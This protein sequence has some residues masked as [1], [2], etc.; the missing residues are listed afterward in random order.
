MDAKQIIELL[1]GTSA[2]A[3]LCE[4]SRSAVSQWGKKNNIPKAQLKFLKVAKAEVF[5]TV[6]P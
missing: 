1:G 4:V 5:K 2:T 6:S 3:R